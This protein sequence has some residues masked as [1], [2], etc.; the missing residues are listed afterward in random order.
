MDLPSRLLALIVLFCAGVACTMKGGEVTATEPGVY[1]CTARLAGFEH[2]PTYVF[3]TETADLEYRLG[4]G[5][6]SH[7]ELTTVDGERI[8]LPADATQPPGYFCEKVVEWELTDVEDYFWLESHADEIRAEIERLDKIPPWE[9][10]G[11]CVKWELPNRCI[12][13]WF[14]PGEPI[15]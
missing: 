14:G 15:R 11:E 7:M 4:V 3:D 12:E 5:A 8:S 1:E 9:K 6:P 2:F 13:W 10:G